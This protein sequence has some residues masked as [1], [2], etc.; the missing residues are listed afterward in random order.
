MIYSEFRFT[1]DIRAL[2]SQVSLGVKKGETGRRLRIHLTENGYPYHIPDNCYAVFT[3]KKPDGNKIFNDCVIQDC[4]IFYDVT[5]Q[6]VSTTGL[7]PCA[8]NLYGVEGELL[9][10][11]TFQMI[12]Y[13]APVDQSDIESTSEYKALATLIA[14]AQALKDDM[15]EGGTG[16]YYLPEV[17]QV[18]DT[19]LRIS[20]AP[21]SE[22]MPAVDPVEV[23]LP[24]YS[25]DDST[26]NAVVH[27][28]PTPPEDTSV[29]WVDTSDDTEAD[30][31]TYCDAAIA[32]SL[33]AAKESGE[34]DGVDGQDG[35]YY[36][37]SLTQTDD[38]TVRFMFDASKDGMPRVLDQMIT[39]PCGPAGAN[40]TTPVR[41]TDY[42][43][44]A[45]KAEI[46]SYVDEAILGGAW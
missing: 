13:S 6:T 43:T 21:S 31:Q 45:D 22:E 18:D 4:E 3:A 2:T 10:S 36:T 9:I 40:G 12:V 23:K 20:F 25:G 30:V 44:D 35:G 17:E 38:N 37:P 42:W 34:F 7:L 15:E 14:E 46:K 32:A 1:L 28:G 26:Q 39:L 29:I 33:T 19:T 24:E 16:G 5:E 11:A 41:G 8:I 27:V